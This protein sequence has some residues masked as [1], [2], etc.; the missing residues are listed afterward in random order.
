MAGGV[1]ALD[2]A[3]VRLPAGLLGIVVLAGVSG[4]LVPW[5]RALA[6]P[7]L[8][9]AIAVAAFV[10]TYLGIWLSQLAIGRARSTAVASTLLATSP[11]FALPLGRW[12]N[13]ERL[14]VALSSGPCSPA[15]VW[16]AS[17]WVSLEHICEL[18]SVAVVDRRPGRRRGPAWSVG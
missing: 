9:A 5:T 10:G 11:I 8:L 2:T 14:T 6:N 15:Q 3:L 12:L 13:A 17:L 1:S 16:P 7:R 4:R 18:H